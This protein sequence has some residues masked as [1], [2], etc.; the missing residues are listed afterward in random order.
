MATQGNLVRKQY[1]ISEDN[2]SKL[3]KLARSNHTSAAAIVRLAIDAYDPHG[4]NTM[5]TP[6]LMELVSA[7]LK[8]AIASTKIAHQ[9]V[10][11]TLKIVN[12]ETH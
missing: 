12:E 3:D 2:I 7:R 4:A 9:K 1:L 6:E 5:D 10:A 11:K 8:D